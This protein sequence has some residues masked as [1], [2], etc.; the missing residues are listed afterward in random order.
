MALTRLVLAGLSPWRYVER[1]GT[2]SISKSI[3]LARKIMSVWGTIGNGGLASA[4]VDMSS[5]GNCAEALTLGKML[6]GMNS[7][8]SL[9]IGI[10]PESHFYKTNPLDSR[11]HCGGSL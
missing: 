5:H 7:P 3:D 10:M 4:S 11:Y 9:L 6:E 1:Q 2:E 8:G